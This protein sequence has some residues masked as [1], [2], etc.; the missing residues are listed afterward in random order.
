M[1]VTETLTV[2]TPDEFR[3]WLEQ[4]ARTRKEVWLVIFKKA[5]GLPTIAYDEAVEAALCFGWIDGMVKALDAKRY[6]Q[7]FTPRRPGSH[8]TEANL[9]KARRLIAEGRMTAAGR[10]VLPPGW[11]P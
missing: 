11:E 3:S 4:N 2:T 6:A 9:A 7:R 8:W 10:G 1:N 5:S